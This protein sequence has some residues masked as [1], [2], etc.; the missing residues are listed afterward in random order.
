MAYITNAEISQLITLP[1]DITTSQIDQLIV[2][3]TSIINRDINHKVIR[4]KVE[5]IDETREND[6]DGSNATYYIKNWKDW[7][8]GDMNNDGSITISDIEVIGV[9]SSD[10]EHI[11]TVSSITH[12]EGKIVLSSAPPSSYDLY[13]THVISPVDEKTPDSI[14]KIAMAQLIGAY[15]FLKI[16]PQQIAK[17][18]IGKVSV[19][20]QSQGFKMLFDEYQKTLN[21]IKENTIEA[22]ECE[23]LIK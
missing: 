9:D 3:C 4:E 18:K 13:V 11:L 6:I 15:A 22:E 7:Y 10:V 2:F 12:D 17:F 23:V 21:R 8:L 19:T 5:W 1:S 20:Q 16:D 14:I